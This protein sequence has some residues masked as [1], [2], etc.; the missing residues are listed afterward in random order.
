MKSA[1]SLDEA[2]GGPAGPPFS[3]NFWTSPYF[4]VFRGLERCLDGGLPAFARVAVGMVVA[5]WLYVPVHELLHALGCVATGGTVTRLEIAP[6][7]GGHLFA[8]IFPF[9]HPASE[10]AGRLSGF[11]T[12]GSDFVYLATDLAPFLLTLFPGFWWLRRAGRR[13]DAFSYG[14]SLPVA[15]APLTS[16]TGDAYEIGSILATR[17]PP[18]ATSAPSLRGDDLIKKVDELLSAAAPGSLWGG[19]VV[20]VFLAIGWVILTLG[21]SGWLAGRAGERP[22]PPR[23]RLNLS[24]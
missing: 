12:G 11:S 4:D 9:V 21:L 24:R 18:F 14:A 13:G 20:A 10:Y 6:L 2:K 7:Y 3:S 17:L 16:L 15:L 22:L 1:P 23:P 5:W 8:A 19:L